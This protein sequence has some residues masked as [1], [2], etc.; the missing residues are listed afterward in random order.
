MRSWFERQTLSARLGVTVG[1]GLV[2]VVALILATVRF[3]LTQQFATEARGRLAGIVQIARFGLPKTFRIDADKLFAGDVALDGANAFVDEI[4]R[5]SGGGVVSILRGDRVVTTSHRTAD[6]RPE[7][8]ATAPGLTADIHR[9]D[10]FQNADYYGYYEL[11]RDGS[12]KAIGAFAIHGPKSNFDAWVT[13]IMTSILIVAVPM[14]LVVLLTVMWLVR[15]VTGRLER[16]RVVMASVAGGDLSVAVPFVGQPT[17]VGQMADAVEVF[18]TN[19]LHVAELRAAADEGRRSAEARAAELGAEAAQFEQRTT[20]V[21]TSLVSAA[22]S[23]SERAENLTHVAGSTADRAGSAADAAES[24]SANVETVAAAAEELRASVEE[25]G[26]QVVSATGIAGEA[27][28]EAEATN[29]IVQGLSVAA[30][31]IGE[32]VGLITE[33]AGQTNLL[34]LNATI[35]A[36]RAGDAGKGFAVVATEVKNLAGQTARATEEIQAQVTAIRTETESAVSAITGITRT[37]DSI[38]G[39]TTAIAAGVEEQ[40]AA[41][42]EIARSVSDAANGTR[43]VSSATAEVTNLA[44]QTG[45][46]A[47]EFLIAAD[48]LNHEATV[49]REE[50]DRFL[51]AVRAG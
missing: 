30:Q 45:V 12:G 10:R 28:R 27:V 42:A 39:I 25:I 35:E 13:S 43:V 23:L 26:R 17:E 33:I 11:I 37:I 24:A 4:S 34:A 9:T 41:T 15:S 3:D 38:S 40:S 5:V 44:G 50:V 2:L 19:A 51:G 14:A 20:A 46:S 7:L 47:G 16:V 49:L 48:E 22:A 29:R 1:G 21:V 6:G 31:R 18:K 32:V 36:A 8:F